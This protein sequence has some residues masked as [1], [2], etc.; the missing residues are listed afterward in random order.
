MTG[1]AATRA[2]AFVAAIGAGAAGEGAQT[3]SA[4]RVAAAAVGSQIIAAD[5]AR[6]LALVLACYDDDATLWPPDAAPVTGHAAIRPRYEELFR[7]SNPQLANRTTRVIVS[8]DLATIEGEITG[9][10]VSRLGGG[11]RQ[12]HDRY[13]MLLAKRAGGWRITHLVWRRV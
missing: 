2:I 5:N 4:D 3:S 8:G 6:N 11:D 12:V 13:L 1:S 7:A 10:F 9:R